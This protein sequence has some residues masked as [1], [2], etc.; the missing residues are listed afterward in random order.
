MDSAMK[1]MSENYSTHHSNATIIPT[2]PSPTQSTYLITLII[3]EEKGR[4]LCDDDSWYLVLSYGNWRPHLSSGN[5]REKTRVT[6]KDDGSGRNATNM[7][8]VTKESTK[9][10]VLKDS[11]SYHHALSQDDQE[12]WEEACRSELE[13]FKRM[14]VFEEV[15]KPNNSKIIGCK[16]V[17][18]YKLGPDGQ[19]KRYK[20]HLVVQG[21]LQIEGIDYNETFATVTKFKSIWLS[22]AL[23]A[24]F[25]WEIHQMDV[26][27]TFLNGELNE[28]IYMQVPPGYKAAPRM[29]WQL[30]RHC[31][32][33]NKQVK[34]GTR[35][36]PKNSH[37]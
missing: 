22:L 9:A 26:K 31:M 13:T 8:A 28:K 25:D 34:S 7:T 17:F 37:C 2:K 24:F 33:W 6:N 4:C 21:F 36:C 20:A 1:N 5:P 15:K 11:I 19:I 30:K 35:N 23:L 12:K 32:A 14:E 18:R 27:S 29:V 16:W 3:L 10:A